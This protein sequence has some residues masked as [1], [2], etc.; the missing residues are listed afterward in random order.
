MEINKFTLSAFFILSTLILSAQDDIIQVGQKL[1]EFSI[2]S[3]ET[4]LKSSDLSGKVV[5][6]NF[7]ATWCG[8]CNAE[9]PVLQQKVWNKNK[10][11]ADFRLLIIGR[12]QSVATIDSFKV[13]KKFNM[14]FYSDLDRS[15]Y[16]KFA[17]KYIPRN[18]I[19]DK[20]GKIV[21][22]SQGFNESEFEEMT[23]KLE[24]LLEK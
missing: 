8:P 2:R 13:K 3:K 9:L 12:E 17:S 14:P 23:K 5:L 24:E 22:A 16:S 21:F 10:N 7:F 18:Y 15:A 19:V 11:N 20:S 6:I 4:V 1:P